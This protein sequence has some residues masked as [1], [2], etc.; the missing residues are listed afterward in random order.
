MLRFLL[1]AEVGLP[2]MLLGGVALCLNSASFLK[3][4]I[5][6]FVFLRS[7]KYLGA[8]ACNDQAAVNFK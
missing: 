2:V 4:S 6:A 8:Q 1:T 3:R 5:F 7:K